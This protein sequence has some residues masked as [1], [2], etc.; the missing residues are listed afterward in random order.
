MLLSFRNGGKNHIVKSSFHFEFLGIL[1]ADFLCKT[2]SMCTSW[3]FTHISW[4]LRNVSC[5][6][7]NNFY[8]ATEHHNLL[9]TAYPWFNSM[10]FHWNSPHWMLSAQLAIGS[11]ECI[12]YW[13]TESGQIS[14]TNIMK[15]IYDTW[16]L[17]SYCKRIKWNGSWWWS[18]SL[19]A[20]SNF[21]FTL[22]H[23]F[24][25]VSFRGSLDVWC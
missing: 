25:A 4:L 19:K 12:K 18:D 10:N 13:N 2:H 8:F 15:K 17:R 16:I 7:N 22:Q 23:W 5:V 14:N 6:H 11:L 24:I 21:A 9:Q 1:D 20:L 3:H